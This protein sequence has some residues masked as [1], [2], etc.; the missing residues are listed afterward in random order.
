MIRYLFLALGLLW[1]G[2]LSASPLST[3]FGL[4]D[5]KQLE[6]LPHHPHFKEI[7]QQVLERDQVVFSYRTTRKILFGRLHLRQDSRG[8]YVTD[9]YCETDYH[10]S[11]F[12]SQP[13]G[14]DK[15]PNPN[16]L[17]TEHTWPQS[18]FSNR[19]PKS[20]QKVDLHALFPVAS[21]VNSSRGNIEFGEVG[22]NHETPCP[23]A[24]RGQVKNGA[25]T[26]FEPPE[27]HKGNVARALFYFSL[28]YEIGISDQEEGYLRLWHILD[29]VDQ[30][31]FDRNELIYQ[32]QGNRNP[33][34]DRPD[35]SDAILDF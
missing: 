20:M 18:R 9:V 11:D 30:E 14:P 27:S 16:I 35:W 7:V 33:F 10:E 31:E 15:I 1:V 4:T 3:Y 2:P 21:R 32:I 23:A 12:R 34:I 24:K 25:A 28:R 26:V 8:Y 29:P 6:E 22:E 19:H 13:P 5:A 17:N